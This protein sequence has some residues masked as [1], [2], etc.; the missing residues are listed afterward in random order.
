VPDP[1]YVGRKSCSP[2]V[3]SLNSDGYTLLESLSEKDKPWDKHR[4]N[5][6]IIAGYYREGGMESY[7]DRISQCSQ[8]LEFRELPDPKTGQQKLKLASAK[9][10]RVRHCPICQWRRSLQWKARAYENLPRVVED[11]PHG[12]WMFL[13]LTLKNCPL[14]DL[15]ETLAHLNESFRRL[16]QLKAFPGVG[17]IKSVEIT[18]GKDGKSA[19]PHLH[20]LI[21]LKDSYYEEGYL[22]KKEWIALWKQSLRVDYS[23]ILD[24]KAVCPK[25]SPVALIAE[26]LKYQ[27]KESDMVV[28]A[29]WFLEYVKQV[30]GTRAIGI[31]GVLQDYFK[32]VGEEPEDLIGHHEDDDLVQSESAQSFYFRWHRPFK[33]Y[34][35][36]KETPLG[37]VPVF[38]QNHYDTG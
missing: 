3:S 34:V 24:I 20:C 28:S 17:W 15:R 18:R 21:L 37:F 10:C 25:S 30:H 6:D 7:A 19:H 29:E 26:I 5:A 27:C 23:P 4:R 13:T 11:Y 38:T 22:S 33:K 12:R 8:L 2:I 16:T 36:V 35:M 14:I 31:G 9:F 1:Q 32:Q